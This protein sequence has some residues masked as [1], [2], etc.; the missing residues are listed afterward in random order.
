MTP[1]NRA[2]RLARST[3]AWLVVALMV[4]LSPPGIAS[5]CPMGQQ[6][7]AIASQRT[8]P[9]SLDALCGLPCCQHQAVEDRQVPALKV[10]LREHAVSFTASPLPLISRS[11][12]VSAPA[13]STR[14]EFVRNSPSLVVLY[15]QFLI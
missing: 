7:G 15:A 10:S 6:P 1:M 5:C 12:G 8:G 9:A 2:K 13:R 14:A 11:A 3:S 4:S